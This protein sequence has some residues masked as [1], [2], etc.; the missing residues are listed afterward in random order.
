MNTF[1]IKI[2]QESKKKPQADMFGGT[3]YK[4]AGTF[5]GS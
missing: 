4:T 3:I 2:G 1:F 5:F